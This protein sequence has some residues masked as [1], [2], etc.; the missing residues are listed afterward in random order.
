MCNAA[1][2]APNNPNAAYDNDHDGYCEDVDCDDSNPSIN[3]GATE[4]CGNGIDD[5]CVGGDA[6]CD[7]LGCTQ[8][9]IAYCISMG[10]NCYH[11]LCYTPVLVDLAGDGFQLTDG[12]HGVDFDINNDGI[13]EHLAW[14]AAHA[15]DAWLALD[16]NGNGRID[17]GAELFGNVTPQPA[18]LPGEAKNGFRALA[19]YDQPAQ[20]GNG[21][22][23]ITKQDTIF[24]SLRLWQD[25]NHNGVSEAGELHGLQDL[26][27]KALDLDYRASKRTDRYGNQFR[28]RAKVKDTHD[29]QL[30]R[31]AWDVCL[32]Q[33]Q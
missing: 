3:P 22:G 26:G 7:E 17:N 27:L 10:G 15:D 14:T 28:Y 33:G 5:D 32:V 21:A 19:A 23:L 6:T 20:G 1:D 2:C 4:I 12:A 24:A 29:A 30:G 25:T 9:E 11:G 16:R 8:A 18:L 31:W 13:A